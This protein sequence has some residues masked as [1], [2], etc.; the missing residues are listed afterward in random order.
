MVQLRDR[1]QLAD[2]RSK[3]K[4]NS[5]EWFYAGDMLRNS[6]CRMNFLKYNCACTFADIHT[7]RH[8]HMHGHHTSIQFNLWY[9]SLDIKT[10]V[11]TIINMA[12]HK[13]LFKLI[14]TG[15]TLVKIK[16]F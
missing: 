1:Q 16:H 13:Y 6:V 2:Y 10:T 9:P 7:G 5:Q 12:S 14:V 3:L 4:P 15:F 11:L 8:P